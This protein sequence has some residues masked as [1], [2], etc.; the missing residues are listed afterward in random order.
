M[1]ILGIHMKQVKSAGKF[2]NKN[3]NGY[4]INDTDH[5]KIADAFQPLLSQVKQIIITALKDACHSIYLTG[6]IPRGIAIVGQSDLDIFAIV[7]S[8]FDDTAL[9]YIQEQCNLLLIKNKV[10]SK[11]DVE[12]W[13]FSEVF[14][15]AND[16]DNIQLKLTLSI[17]DA[18]LKNSS[19]CIYGHDVIT[20]IP[21]IKPSIALANDEL[22]MLHSDLAMATKSITETPTEDNV[23]YWCKRV[24]KNIIRAGF[25]LVMA[26]IE[27]YTRDID[28]CAKVL[29]QHYPNMT[30]SIHQ[31]VNWIDH[32]ITNE[33]ELLNFLNDFGSIFL[34]EV[35]RWMD[36]HNPKRAQELPRDAALDRSKPHYLP[37]Q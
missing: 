36:Y 11:I 15:L 37:N 21:P 28:L 4:L 32:P 9:A 26:L 24:M 23:R 5:E 1:N 10:V 30:N 33:H 14:P 2:W 35:D 13:E 16:N 17:Y 8:T 34:H 6:S 7:N 25:C 20:F 22:I 18:I 29:T 12:F 31:A 19:L 27:E 3:E